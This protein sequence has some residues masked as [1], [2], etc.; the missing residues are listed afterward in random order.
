MRRPDTHSSCAKQREARVVGCSSKM[1][2]IQRPCLFIRFCL[3]QNDIQALTLHTSQLIE[4]PP[5]RK[6]GSYCLHSIWRPVMTVGGEGSRPTVQKRLKT[7]QRLWNTIASP[8]VMH[9][10]T[11]VPLS[12]AVRLCSDF[13]PQPVFLLPTFFSMEKREWDLPKGNASLL[14]YL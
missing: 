8:W 2:L 13:G 14:S 11:L 4:K 7:G 3:I 12:P 5:R 9:V 10:I 1:Y 6:P